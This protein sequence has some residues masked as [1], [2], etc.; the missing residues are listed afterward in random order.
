MNHEILSEKFRKAFGKNI[1]FAARDSWASFIR[2][3]GTKFYFRW[4]WIRDPRFFLWVSQNGEL[5]IYDG[6]EWFG[7]EIVEV[8]DD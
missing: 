6:E 2:E 7:V 5:D 3:R 4:E 8:S 1:P